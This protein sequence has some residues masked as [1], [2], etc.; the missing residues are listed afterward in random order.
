MQ[1]EDSK[2]ASK[3]KALM[4]NLST[5]L[6]INVSDMR[7]WD[8]AATEELLQR[9]TR[10]LP[11]LEAAVKECVLSKAADYFEKV[12]TARGIERVPGA[13]K[14]DRISVGFEGNFGNLHVTPRTLSSGE[15]SEYA[16]A[17]PV[18]DTSAADSVA[19]HS[20]RC[21]LS[22]MVESLFLS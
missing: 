21:F 11:V 16:A 22:L 13:A 10:L 7:E 8:R 1:N 2:Y 15:P 20:A 14:Y 18:R 6:I 9:P 5:R 12:D 4:E 17:N 19:K 3:L